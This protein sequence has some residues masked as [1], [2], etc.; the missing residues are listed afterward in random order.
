M[1]DD[2]PKKSYAKPEIILEMA[3]ETRAGSTPTAEQM[4]DPFDIQP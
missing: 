4:N 1:I 3:L 2:E